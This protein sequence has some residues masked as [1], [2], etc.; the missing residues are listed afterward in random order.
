MET[1]EKKIVKLQQAGLAHF[2]DSLPRQSV[3]PDAHCM[4]SLA[5]IGGGNPQIILPH[6]RYK[7]CLSF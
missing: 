6:P 7:M 4:G 5:T 2:V 3:L 1:I